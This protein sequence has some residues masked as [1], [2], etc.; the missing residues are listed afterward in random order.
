MAG[1]AHSSWAGSSRRVAEYV[2]NGTAVVKRH[3]LKTPLA[4]HFAI[5]ADFP[6]LKYTCMGS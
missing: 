1:E 5:E 3:P 2:Q 6:Q 4:R